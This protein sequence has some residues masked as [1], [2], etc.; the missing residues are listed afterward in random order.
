MCLENKLFAEIN[1]VGSWPVP[2][3]SVPVLIRGSE[4]STCTA[5]LGSETG[6]FQSASIF[7]SQLPFHRSSIFISLPRS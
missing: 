5:A 3:R 2:Q 1:V 7:F 4:C 6:V